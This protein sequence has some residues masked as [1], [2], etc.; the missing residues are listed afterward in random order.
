MEKIKE[1][2]NAIRTLEQKEIDFK[3][4][5][6]KVDS[7][8]SGVEVAK[9]LG[10]PVEKVYKTLVTVGKSNNHYV[11]VIPAQKE[12]DLKKSAKIANEKSVE[13]L[14]SKDLLPLTGY[15]HGGCSPVGMKKMFSTFV[16]SSAE[17]MPTI[18]VSGGKIGFQVELSPEDLKK[19]VPFEFASV[20]D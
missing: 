7:A 6:F 1:K 4:Y 9:I 17:N 10:V 20:T 16:D 8:V 19:I 5:S 12:L 2:T 3:F 15:V 13:M 11:F 14:K 18:I